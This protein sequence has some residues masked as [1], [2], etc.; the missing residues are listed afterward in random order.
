MNGGND[1]LNTIVPF[2]DHTYLAARSRI[3]LTGSQL[4]PIDAKTGLHPSLA[5]LY[6]H[7]QSGR[8]A[9]VQNVGYP[10][11]DMSHFV[12]DDIWEKAVLQPA[13]EGRGWLGRALDQLYSQDAEGLHGVV[14]G[15]DVPALHGESVKSPV[16]SDPG[17]F[18]YPHDDPNQYAALQ[19]LFRPA[20]EPNR[21]YVRQI[22]ELAIADADAVQRAF[23][24]YQT[25]VVY[26]DS[27]LA[28]S[29][30]LTASILAADLGPRVFWIGQGGYDTH[31][32]QLGDHEKLLAELDQSLDAFYRDL[33][34]HGQE[35]PGRRHDVLGV[36]AAGRGQRQRRD[37]P[38][39]GGADVRPRREG[40]RRV[41]RKCRR[42]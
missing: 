31:N 14:L 13:E 18:N 28:S 6:R 32:S 19:A 26:P 8:L 4:L 35:Q 15:G 20:D 41:L 21:D 40:A 36:R 27:G 16:V 38:R 33:V 3:A 17:S 34:E 9:I 10:R 30:R 1:G 7:L 29:L 5:S 22:G 25:S 39:L 2:A 12:S 11:P 42:L 23:S 37:R 24:E